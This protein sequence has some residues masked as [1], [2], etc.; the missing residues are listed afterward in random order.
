MGLHSWY[1]AVKINLLNNLIRLNKIKIFPLFSIDGDKP[2]HHS[3]LANEFATK[4]V[5]NLGESE[6]T[7]IKRDNILKHVLMVELGTHPLNIDSSV[8][9]CRL[10]CEF[11]APLLKAANVDVPA[12]LLL[13]GYETVLTNRLHTF[14][15][16]MKKK[17]LIYF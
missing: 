7:L 3:E 13:I 5:A 8:K 4:V 12:K 2:G 9:L 10:L 15:N 11:F 1:F 16:D 6:K 14:N 17:A